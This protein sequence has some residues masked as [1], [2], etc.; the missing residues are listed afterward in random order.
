M[1]TA[2][3]RTVILYLLIIAGLRLIVHTL[4]RRIFRF[5]FPFLRFLWFFLLRPL[6]SLLL[7]LSA[8]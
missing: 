7:R 3:V 2:F 5:F 8:V 4:L 6:R 1:I